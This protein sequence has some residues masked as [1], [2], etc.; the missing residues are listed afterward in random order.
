MTPTPAPRVESGR[1]FSL[2]LEALAAELV[3]V[4][5]ALLPLAP[6]VALQFVFFG[7]RFALVSAG[8]LFLFFWWLIQPSL[9]SLDGQVIKRAEAPLLFEAVDELRRKAA[10]PAI[11]S[12]I[13]DDELNA[14]AYQSGGFLSLWGGRRTLILGVPLLRLLSA[15]EVKAVI[16]HELGHFSRNHGRL[17]HWIYGV[18]AKWS[19]YLHADGHDNGMDRVAKRIA[20]WFVPRFIERSADWS[21]TCEY[22]ADAVAAKV[23]RPGDLVG[24][25]A[26]LE[27][28]NLVLREKIAAPFKA[29]C[30]QDPQAPADFW[31][32][33]GQLIEE[34]R[35][36]MPEA[37][38]DITRRQQRPGDSHPPLRERAAML[39]TPVASPA[40]LN[41]QHAGAALL[42]DG[43]LEIFEL[44]QSNWR[45]AAEANWRFDHLHLQ[46]LSG[47]GAKALFAGDTPVDMELAAAVVEEQLRGGES[48][49][50]TLA[51]LAQQ[52]MDN[53]LAQYYWG[54]AC[55]A[56]RDDNGIDHLRRAIGLDKRLATR[57]QR[58]ICEHLSHGRDEKAL[59]AAHLRRDN[60][61]RRLK[62]LYQQVWPAL[63]TGP[64][65]QIPAGAAPLLIETLRGE[66]VTDACW[67]AQIELPDAA[68][69]LHSV[70]VLVVRLNHGNAGDKAVDE[71]LLQARYAACLRA[72]SPPEQLAMVH[73]TYISEP[74]NPRLLAQLQALPD[75]ELITPKTPVNLDIL[76]IDSL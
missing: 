64:L 15:D 34:S 25:L 67:A 69:L 59:K 9:G 19:Y 74:L 55:L 61:L 46:W 68:G 28:A 29:L 57:A 30:L 56:R 6:V 63:R 3:F 66:A 27:F 62:P 13:L 76:R 5:V 40:P 12:I 72:V 35:E 49:L 36:A 17:G 60:T 65:R 2:T 22:E 50:A 11:H 10:A 75:S 37:L 7:P 51:A 73:T 26:R 39:D 71:D 18:R 1:Y 8:L 31:D 21:R 14:A 53:A 47:G 33:A 20:A 54:M 4:V 38:A 58:S 42:G 44:C 24:G 48:A 41:N 52:S 23:T 16:A 70:N 45:K 43:W 32:R